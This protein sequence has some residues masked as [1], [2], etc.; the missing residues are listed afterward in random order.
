MNSFLVASFLALGAATSFT[1]D[2]APRIT[3]LDPTST[4]FRDVHVVTM[5][6]DAVLAS[7]DVRVTNG[8][9]VAIDDTLAPEDGER[10]IE[11]GGKA[12][13]TPGFVDMHL[14]LPP[15]DGTEKT[16]ARR[17]LAL[18]LAHGVTTVRGLAGHPSHPKLRDRVARGELLG[19][20]LYVAG[21]ALHQG[22]VKTED[23]ARE[24][25]RA[26]HLAGYD[27]VKSHHLVDTAVWQAAADMARELGIPTAGHVT[28]EVGLDRVLEA[29]QQVEHLD[30]FIAALCPSLD[31]VPPFGQFPS[32]EALD[33]VDLELLPQRIT[34]FVD[35][36][37][38]NTPTLA[39]FATICDTKTPTDEFVARDD[40]TYVSQKAREAWAAA[41]EQQLAA[42]FP[43]D[44]LGKRF[45]E[46]RRTITKALA[47]AGAPILVGSD[48]PQNFLVEGF[49][50]HREMRALADAGLSP[51]QVLRAA[52]TAPAEYLAAL[53]RFGSASGLAVDFGT[54]A[55]NQRADLVLLRADPN[56]NVA[57]LEAIDGVMVRGKWL[58]RA[59][60]D[61]LLEEFA[62]R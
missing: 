38:P 62:T 30:G 14:H 54:L 3:P 57:N 35:T 58:D 59:A 37:L 17:T 22:S 40:M 52:T 32:V 61:A 9:I 15:D 42:G 48:C 45:V 29:K 4:L 50:T 10:V 5:I 12:W 13:L 47:D 23:A 46:L 8:L 11:G 43:S 31:G 28:N 51:A 6:D 36:K 49:A 7:H 56:S 41:R 19:P 26:Q 55:R 44:E 39:L 27:L 25:V 18:L 53:P 2:E 1:A 21:P 16:P 33:R 24:A 34:R 60:L 20:T